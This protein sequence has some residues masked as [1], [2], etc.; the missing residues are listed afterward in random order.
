[1]L[2][3]TSCRSFTLFISAFAA[4]GLASGK[5]DGSVKLGDKSGEYSDE[6]LPGLEAS[7]KM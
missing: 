2:V 7:E 4:S 6:L 5:R 1:V 3:L